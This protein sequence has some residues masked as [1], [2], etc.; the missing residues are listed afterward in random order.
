MVNVEQRADEGA[1]DILMTCICENND[2]KAAQRGNQASPAYDANLAS[3][4]LGI[5]FEKVGQHED[6]EIADGDEGDHARI[7]EGIKTS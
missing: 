5:T 1:T 2:R 3:V 4:R 7:F 6:D